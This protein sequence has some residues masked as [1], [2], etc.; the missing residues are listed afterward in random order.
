MVQNYNLQIGTIIRNCFLTNSLK[1]SNKKLC[2]AYHLFKI[3]EINFW[4]IIHWNDQT[5][6][7]IMLTIGSKLE[8]KLGIFAARLSNSNWK[9]R[10]DCAFIIYHNLSC[11]RG[12]GQY[13]INLS[14]IKFLFL[15][16]EYFPVYEMLIRKLCDSA[17]DP[18]TNF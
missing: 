2:N 15:F 16:V 6:N 4:R 10:L 11:I 13:K 1:W 17:F 7:F 5:R 8:G 12:W 14:F 9:K 3:I 18:K